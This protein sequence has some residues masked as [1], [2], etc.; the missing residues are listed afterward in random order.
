VRPIRHPSNTPWTSIVD[1]F[2][3]R[4]TL[5]IHND[6]GLVCVRCNGSLERS[7][8]A[9]PEGRQAILSLVVLPDGTYSVHANGRQIL[10]GKG[11]QAMTSLVPLVAGPFADSIT[12]GRNAPDGWSTFNGHIGAVQLYTKALSNVERERL[13]NELTQAFQE[14]KL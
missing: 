7:E 13:E 8:T 6:T 2:Y 3:D 4:L 12:I 5:G 1:V 10:I 14:R 9:L 11:K